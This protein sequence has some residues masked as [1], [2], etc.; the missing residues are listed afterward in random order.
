MTVRA[1]NVRAHQMHTRAQY[2]HTCTVCTRARAHTHT[3]THEHKHKHK[4]TRDYRSKNQRCDVLGCVLSESVVVPPLA[5]N[6][7][8]ARMSWYRGTLTLA[9]NDM[10][11]DPMQRLHGD[12]RP[13]SAV[14]D[15]HL[16]SRAKGR[17]LIQLVLQYQR[18]QLVLQYQRLPTPCP[19]GQ[20]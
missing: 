9:K 7:D 12:A 8:C 5:A 19:K 20:P 3:H 1:H 18:I 11:V 6:I 13:S 2:A 16:C 14:R 15:N 17:S 4:H 10:G